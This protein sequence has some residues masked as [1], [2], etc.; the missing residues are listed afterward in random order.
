MACPGLFPNTSTGF[1]LGAADYLSKPVERDRLV[2]S[3]E[4]LIGAGEGKTIFVIEDDDELRFVLKE[5]LTKESYSVIEAENGRAALTELEDGMASPDLILLDL[6]MPVMNGF[7]FLQVYRAKF[8]NDVPIVVVTGAD[9]TEKDKKY[10]S[11]EV[12]RI[13]EKTP[14]TEGTIAAD[15]ARVL[16]SVRME[17]K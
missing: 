6:N 10:L 5:A 16:R 12:T 7:E 2:S 4:K 8:S 15:V 3:I 17:E 9:L 13:L 14:D 11:G 1:S